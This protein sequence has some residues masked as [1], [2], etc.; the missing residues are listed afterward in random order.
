MPF[1]FR[2]HRMTPAL[3]LVIMVLSMVE[4][5]G[6]SMP[7]LTEAP[8]AVPLEIESR[9]VVFNYPQ[10]DPYDRSNLYGFSH[11]PSVATLPDGRLLCV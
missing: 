10:T 9:S 1:S 2:L 4:G 11:A 3:R 8:S 5:I 7:V 6:F